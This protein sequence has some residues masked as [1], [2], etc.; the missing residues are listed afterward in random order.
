MSERP[1]QIDGLTCYSVAWDREGKIRTALYRPVKGPWTPTLRRRC[2]SAQQGLAETM[3][4]PG[5]SIAAG[6][7]T[8]A[9]PNATA[10]GRAHRGALAEMR[11][12]Q[13]TLDL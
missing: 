5:R 9:S 8:S 3:E 7:L 6:D 2:T 12:R 13:E 11:A 4:Q 10:T 1:R